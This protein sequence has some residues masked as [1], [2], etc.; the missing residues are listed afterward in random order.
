MKE[1]Q[2]LKIKNKGRSEEICPSDIGYISALQNYVKLHLKN[3]S[4]FIVHSTLK[5][6]Y[7]MLNPSGFVMVH[8]SYIVNTCYIDT[9]SGRQLLLK[10]MGEVP[11]GRLYKPNVQAIVHHGK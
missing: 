11:I 2:Y 1:K 3:G 6:C 10:G 8:K 5:R 7:D 4:S 9:I